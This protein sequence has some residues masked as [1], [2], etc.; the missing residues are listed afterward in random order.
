MEQQ[1]VRKVCNV[2]LISFNIKPNKKQ[3]VG[4]GLNRALD[5]KEYLMIIL[6]IS[7]QNHIVTPHQNCLVERVQMRGYNICFRPH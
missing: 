4:V 2:F 7:H 5:K 6:L 1:N 3:L